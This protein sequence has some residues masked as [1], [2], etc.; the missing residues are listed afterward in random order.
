VR[1]IRQE[2]AGQSAAI[3]RAL[4]NARGE[5]VGW[6][7]SD[8]AFFDVRAVERVVAT[9][10]KYPHADVVYGHSALVNAKGLILQLIW[11]PPFNGRLLRFTNF[12]VQPAAFV[13]RSVVGD[14]IVSE[15]YDY[16]MDTDLWL[17][18]LPSHNFKRVGAIIGI[19]RHHSSRKGVARP[20]LV[21]A[22]RARLIAAHGLHN[23]E[24]RYWWMRKIWNIVC[25]FVGVTLIPASMRARLAF[26]GTRGSPVNLLWRQVA[27]PRHAMPP[28]LPA[29][30]PKSSAGKAGS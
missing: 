2:N 21:A 8:D 6:L 11:A 13:R 26:A 23:D 24:L 9:F 12:I 15:D 1:W 19:D 27:V 4:G 5:I 18:L 7:N 30:G 28:G 14:H 16:S 17:R 29:G 10:E 25:R 3:N 22:D 20:D